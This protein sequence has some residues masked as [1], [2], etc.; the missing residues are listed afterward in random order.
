M[1]GRY[2]TRAQKQEIACR[3]NV[4]ENIFD[5]PLPPNFN[6]APSTFQPIIR[7]ARDTNGR[8]MVLA[9]W[10]L[11]PYFVKDIS[12]WKSI[13][14]INAKSETVASLPTY[15]EAYRKRRC[16]VPADGFYEWPEIEKGKKG[17]KHPQV[18][19][20]S[21]GD[22]MAF[23][24]LWEAWFDRDANSWLQTFTICTT[25]ANPL[26]AK[27]HSRI[28]VILHERDWERWLDRDNVD[29]PPDDLLRPYDADE[30]EMKPANPA[31][32]N[33]KNNG[34]EML[35]VPLAVYGLDLEK[36]SALPPEDEQQGGL[37]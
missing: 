36:K 25:E 16:L 20:L 13:T 22:M 1:C 18:F 35:E 31:V 15:R 3:F 19:T 2:I 7:L 4:G 34:P 30:M 28:P 24:G 10:G 29:R 27:I 21:S 6:V 12:A 33:V 32:G 5:D 11:I 26:M 23:A 8:E 17:P 14:T 9:R 37:F